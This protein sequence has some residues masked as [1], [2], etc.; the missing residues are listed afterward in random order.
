ML[1]V[2]PSQLPTTLASPSFTLSTMS[3]V[4]EAT[5]FASS[6]LLISALRS[7]HDLRV[8][9]VEAVCVRPHV[10]TKSRAAATVHVFMMESSLSK[11]S[12]NIV[13]VGDLLQ[14]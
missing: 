7:S 8:G 6:F 5:P 10:H 9:A 1:F 4:Y 14:E 12:I 2:L 13:S 11:R 3:S